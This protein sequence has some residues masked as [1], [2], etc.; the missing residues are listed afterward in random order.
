[1]S[2]PPLIFPH[3]VDAEEVRRLDS[4]EPVRLP[5]Q[6]VAF[7]KAF[8]LLS[9]LF[10]SPL[11][12]AVAVAGVLYGRRSAED[13]GPLLYRETRVSAGRPFSLL[14][15]RILRMRAIREEID[16]GVMPKQVENDPANVTR[17][18]EVLKRTGLDE[19]PQFVNVLVGEMSVVGPR[20]KPVPEYEAEAESGI[21]RRE[22]IRAGL[23]GP[24]QLLKGTSRTFADELLSDLRYIDLVR[25]SSGWRVV[26]ADL[27]IIG[28]TARLMLKMTGE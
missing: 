22:V 8:A 15:F 16:R 18:G 6:K 7:D 12:L 20:P 2:E 26:V 17:V 21:H 13:R 10:T 14:K 4:D 3:P 24:A 1:M 11:W 25:R 23:T 19:V 28:R 5:W 27:A 9:L